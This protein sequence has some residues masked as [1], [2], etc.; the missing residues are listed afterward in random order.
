[1][2]NSDSSTAEQSSTVLSPSEFEIREPLADEHLFSIDLAL[3]RA[4][5]GSQRLGITIPENIAEQLRTRI[6]QEK[7]EERTVVAVDRNILE[8]RNS[9]G[10]WYPLIYDHKTQYHY[11]VGLDGKPIIVRYDTSGNLLINPGISTHLLVDHDLKGN[12]PEIQDEVIRITDLAV[13]SIKKMHGDF[14][15]NFAGGLSELQA[16]IE[17]LPINQ[18]IA[19]MQKLSGHFATH[20]SRIGVREFTS[21]HK[22][23]LGRYFRA[24]QELFE[25]KALASPYVVAKAQTSTGRN[26]IT[27]GVVDI[28]KLSRCVHVAPECV[29]LTYMAEIDNCPFVLFPAEILFA[30]N[31]FSSKFD[32]NPNQSAGWANWE[33]SG[34]NPDSLHPTNQLNLNLGIVFLPKSTPVNPET[35]SKFEITNG[36]GAIHEE[37]IGSLESLIDSDFSLPPQF[38]EVQKQYCT[39]HESRFDTE[40]AR[41]AY[42]QMLDQVCAQAGFKDLSFFQERMIVEHLESWRNHWNHI[43]TNWDNSTPQQR[44]LSLPACAMDQIASREE[45]FNLTLPNAKKYFLRGCLFEAYALYSPTKDAIPAQEYWEKWFSEHPATRPTRII[46]YDGNPNKAIWKF[47]LDNGIISRYDVEQN[48][49]QD[50]PVGLKYRDVKPRFPKDTSLDIGVFRLH[51]WGNWMYRIAATN[52][53]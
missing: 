51:E 8:I 34:D 15:E 22:A 17:T 50:G 33:I 14:D 27:E 20:L 38:V 53:L 26:Y 28:E 39:S 43:K 42:E 49:N 18:Y 10:C 52:N 9:V 2:A 6:K 1:M 25:A 3:R 30:N 29:D 48:W 35:G 12:T 47:L 16:G 41:K 32:F 23:G 36:K 31:T 13:A 4:M 46:Y 7:Q 21:T 24:A 19:L 5:V 37:R 40:S 45:F 44:T 11:Y